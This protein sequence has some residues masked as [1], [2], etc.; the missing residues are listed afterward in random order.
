VHELRRSELVALG[1]PPMLF[2]NVNTSADL[3]GDAGVS[4]R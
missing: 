2:H 4:G 3:P 1:G